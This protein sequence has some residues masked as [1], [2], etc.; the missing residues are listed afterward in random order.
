MYVQR[1]VSQKTAGLCVCESWWGEPAAA[2]AVGRRL[3]RDLLEEEQMRMGTSWGSNEP[4]CSWVY[5][6]GP[7][8][9]TAE[10]EAGEA[11]AVGAE[12][13]RTRH[14]DPPGGSGHPSQQT[15]VPDEDCLE[16]RSWEF[17]NF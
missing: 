1:S 4:Q 15:H 6:L 10:G 14:P 3:P 16:Q 8:D 13:L 12:G 7:P 2:A 17:G 11:R 9:Q 5:F